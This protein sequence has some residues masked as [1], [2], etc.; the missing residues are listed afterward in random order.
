MFF[1]PAGEAPIRGQ[2]LMNRRFRVPFITHAFF[3]FSGGGFTTPVTLMTLP[4][5]TD[6]VGNAIVYLYQPLSDDFLPKKLVP[7]N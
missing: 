6:H 2:T 5:Q 4:N 1:S 3:S 7:H